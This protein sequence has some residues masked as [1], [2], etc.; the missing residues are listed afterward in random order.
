[1]TTATPE[2][3]EPTPFETFQATRKQMSAKAF[4]EL[5][6]DAQWEDDTTTQF[7]VYENSWYIE[8]LDDGRHML[9]IEN[10]GWIT[11]KSSLEEMEQ[12]LFEFSAC[13]RE[14]EASDTPS[15]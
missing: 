15:P 3:S 2:Q 1:M 10:R 4:G 8:I 11:P 14:P 6:G 12:A 7:L 9:A 13:Y 5:I